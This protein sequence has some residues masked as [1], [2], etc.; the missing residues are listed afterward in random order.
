MSTF[1]HE[2]RRG[3]VS[4]FECGLQES[5]LDRA[6]AGAQAVTLLEGFA[7]RDTSEEALLAG[8]RAAARVEARAAWLKAR[9][10]A[11]LAASAR[12]DY[13]DYT[14]VINVAAEEISASLRVSIYQ[15]ERFVAVGEA[16]S[17]SLWATGDALECGA[18]S[19][20]HAWVI[21]DCLRGVELAVALPVEELALERAAERTAGELRR[22][23]AR[24]LVEFDPTGADER[25]GVAAAKRRVGRP[26]PAADGM[27]RMSLFLPAPD[28]VCLDTALDAAATAAH[29]AGDGRT[30]HQLRADVLAGWAANALHNGTVLPD[31]SSVTSVPTRISVTVPLEVLMR[32]LPG[33]V[34]PPSIADV[35][36]SEIGSLLASP[37]GVVGTAAQPGLGPAAGHRTEAA[38]LE[39]YGPI[40]P[41][42]ALLLAAGGTWQRIV[43]DPV[44]GTPLDVGRTRYRAPAE[45][46]A[47]LRL[48]DNT[49]VRP[50]CA[51]P[52]Y[53]CDADH[54]DEWAQGGVTSLAN[55]APECPRHHR[56]KSAGAA[57]VSPLKRDGTR[58]WTTALGRT[59]RRLPERSPRLRSGTPPES[60]GDGT[61]NGSPPY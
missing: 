60:V 44:T 50:G 37:A 36:R 41:S 33:F 31:G 5:L 61:D 55:Q 19:F 14:G 54:V 49:C 21:V 18:I 52:S 35:L 53:R 8:V 6:G 28:A 10:A 17:G 34:A 56:I 32:A 59:Y 3:E 27:A 20:E 57:R 43:T 42:V 13:P 22:D 7:D 24:L 26:R 15:A 2:F 39:G 47:A 45:L 40:A 46:R 30:H 4:V 12:L 16:I 38:W 1:V 23:I 25:A 48:R 9:Y 58:T 51:V 29:A 11:R